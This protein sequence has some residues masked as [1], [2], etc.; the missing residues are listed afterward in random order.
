M[1]IWKEIELSKSGD[2]SGAFL[3]N[4]LYFLK[5]GLAGVS[6]DEIYATGS[7]K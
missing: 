3:A 4:N 6:H 5:S 7:Q 2:K 1:R